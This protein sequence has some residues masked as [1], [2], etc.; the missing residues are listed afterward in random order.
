MSLEMTSKA[1]PSQG[2]PKAPPSSASKLNAIG[3]ETPG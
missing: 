1:A 3:V 2:A